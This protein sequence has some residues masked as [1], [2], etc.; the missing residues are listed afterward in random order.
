MFE[1]ALRYPVDGDDRIETIVIGGLLTLFSWLLIPAVFVAGYLQRVL[2]RTTADDRAPSFDD[3]GDL[4]GEGLKAV[5]VTLAYFA[6]PVVLLTAVLGSVIFAFETT[7]VVETGTTVAEP[8]APG[9]ANN[10]GVVVVLVGFALA[11]VA[12][13]AASY[14][15]PAALARLAVEGRLGAAFEFR[16]LA[17]VLTDR[18]Y[19]I[20]WLVAFVVLAVGGALVGGLASIP[21][22]GWALVPF[23][24]F[25]LNV[26]AFAL[27]GQ[28]YRDATRTD[29]R[30]TA[31]GDRRTSA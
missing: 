22:V 15:L 1:T 17:G 21:L 23:A 6:V 13:L 2:A 3:W 29:R 16:R 19:A 8:A 24:S 12:S 7:T 20:G 26:V 5:A 28:G 27:Y 11:V 25:Y 4:F 30:E 14:A 31:D 9:G 18:S 10:L